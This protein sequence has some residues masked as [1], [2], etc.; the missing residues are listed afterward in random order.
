VY[1][2]A[3]VLLLLRWLKPSH[4][5]SCTTPRSAE[6]ETIV[7]SKKTPMMK[8][9]MYYSKSVRP[10]EGRKP[11]FERQQLRPKCRSLKCTATILAFSRPY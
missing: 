11:R 4:R 2:T 1:F 7:E 5:A 9:S 10:T 8:P 6:R 3:T